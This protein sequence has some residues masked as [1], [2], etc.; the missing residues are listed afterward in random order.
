MTLVD[1]Y[2]YIQTQHTILLCILGALLVVLVAEYFKL[3]RI[4]LEAIERQRE[5]DQTNKS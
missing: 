2:P 4:K 1:L 3:V 5:K